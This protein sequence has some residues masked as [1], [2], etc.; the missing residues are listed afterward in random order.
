MPTKQQTID[1]LKKS[2]LGNRLWLDTPIYMHS[3]SVGEILHKHW[4]SEDVEYAGYLHDIVEDGGYTLAQLKDL[5]Y[6]DHTVHLVDLSTHD[7]SH[8][9]K[10]KAW[11]DMIDRMIQE[12]SK[13]VWAVK[14]AD[15]T[16]NLSECH[17]CSLEQ[18][19]AYLFLKAPAFIYYGN[20][21]FAWTPF[22]NEFLEIYW[23]QVRTH[24]QYFL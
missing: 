8:G 11:L 7:D 16:H 20:K 4:F 3:V 14:L 12:D 24:H 13:D 18:I 17:N 10:R 1:I 21:Y 6:S 23:Q 15:I 22:Y 9:D 5:G 2:I 19:K